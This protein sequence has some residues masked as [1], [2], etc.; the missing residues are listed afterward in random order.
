MKVEI[1][2]ETKETSKDIEDEDSVDN[3]L[4]LGTRIGRFNPCANRSDGSAVGGDEVCRSDESNGTIS[5]NG[6]VVAEAKITIQPGHVETARFPI[7]S[8]TDATVKPKTRVP[9]RTVKKDQPKS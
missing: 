3:L 4:A 9:A 8:Q 5:I 2:E 6:K 7:Q 1:N